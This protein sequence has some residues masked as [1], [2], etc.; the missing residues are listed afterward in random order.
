[1][2]PES[3]TRGSSAQTN[4]GGVKPQM[5]ITRVEVK[6]LFGVFTHVIPFNT[7]VTIIYGLNGVGKTAILRMINGVFNRKYSFIRSVPFSEFTITFDDGS[8]IVITKDTDSI[9][10]SR[11]HG[12]YEAQPLN[13][14]YRVPGDQPKKTLFRTEATPEHFPRHILEEALPGMIQYGPEIWRKGPNG[15]FVTWEELIDRYGDMLAFFRR[16]DSLRSDNSEDWLNELRKKISVRFVETHRLESTPRGRRRG[17]I[18]L[19][20]TTSA[21]S[22]YSEHIAKLIQRLQAEYG[23]KSQ[24]LDRTFPMRVLKSNESK[25]QSITQLTERLQKIE[26]KRER[27]KEIGVLSKDTNPNFDLENAELMSELDTSKSNLLSI[28]IADIEAKLQIFDDISKR[29]EFLIQFIQEH[30]FQK[31]LVID[32]ERGFVIRS[33]VT[34][35]ELSLQQLSSGEQHEL[36]LIYELLFH[37]N[38]NSLI[39]I[40]EPE[41]SL[42]VDWQMQF[43]DDIQKVVGLTPFDVLIATHSPMIINERWDLTVELTQ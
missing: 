1:M 25:A 22:R 7:G 5:K 9:P 3:V 26:R 38:E 30:F 13:A 15:E 19:E 43:L 11:E 31:E 40:D 42:H 32:T 29:I 27:L 18:D 16:E 12:I 35:R 21:L 34:N 37:V 14:E 23:A 6:D 39:L 41:I 8:E 33:T 24:K 4:G 10:N 2:I 28:Y 20:V 17:S 36:V